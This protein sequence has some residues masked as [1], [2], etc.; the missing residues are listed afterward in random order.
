VS[1]TAIVADILLMIGKEF[2]STIRAWRNNSGALPDAHGRLVKFGLVGS[3][4]ILGVIGSEGGRLL[5]IEVKAPGGK[6]TQTQINFANMV[7]AMNGR[8]ILARSVAEARDG[9]LQRIIP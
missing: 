2:H 5:A 4:D 1:E 3:A 7:I 9:L 8:Y 6:R